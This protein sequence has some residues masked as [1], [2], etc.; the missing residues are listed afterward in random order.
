[1]PIPFLIIE[2]MAQY[3][4]LLKNVHKQIEKI[5]GVS[6]TIKFPSYE[7]ILTDS[8][9]ALLRVEWHIHTSLNFIPEIPEKFAD[10]KEQIMLYLSQRISETGNSFAKAKYNE[11]MSYITKSNTYKKAAIDEYIECLKTSIDNNSPNIGM[12]AKH[13]IKLAM[14]QKY[15]VEDIKSILTYALNSTKVE[16]LTKTRI[17]LEAKEEKFFRSSEA[18]NFDERFI[19]LALNSVDNIWKEHNLKLAEYYA[20][21]TESEKLKYVYELLGDYKMTLLMADDPSN[22]Y[23][24]FHNEKRCEEAI[25]YYKIAKCDEKIQNVWLMQNKF[26]E[27]KQYIPLRVTIPQNDE[28][29][30]FL[31]AIYESITKSNTEMICVALVT[32]AGLPYLSNDVLIKYLE[33]KSESLLMFKSVQEDVNGNHREMKDD[34]SK[35]EAYNY[36]MDIV[37]D[38]VSDIIVKSCKTKKI[39]TRKIVDFFYTKTMFGVTYCKEIGG[40]KYEYTWL[41][42]VRFGIESFIKQYNRVIAGKQVNWSQCVDSLSIKFEGILRD[43]IQINGGVTTKLQNGNTSE[44][45]LD[46]ILKM[47]KSSIS[48][49]FYASFN[50]DDLNLFRYAFSSNGH[51]MN[52]RNNV[53]HSFYLPKH[54]NWKIA[55]ISFLALIRLAKFAPKEK[56]L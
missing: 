51:C 52:I 41:E 6:D 29:I 45:T 47:N 18:V 30:K 23:V 34:A 7:D 13:T 56:N 12:L 25:A 4:E 54:Y 44:I 50:E 16:D 1:M 17:F 2:I 40:K 32:G 48:K 24:P 42:Q 35:Y 5:T 20:Q 46:E 3:S 28:K 43:M 14:N 11:C 53:A 55:L 38:L 49:A 21:A 33:E 27:K 39:T 10:G 8:S 31:N 37:C 9:G 36:G 15:R 22:L 19:A 26:K